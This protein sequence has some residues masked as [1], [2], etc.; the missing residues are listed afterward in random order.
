[1]SRNHILRK[2]TFRMTQKFTNQTDQE[3]SDGRE[4]NGKLAFEMEQANKN[5]P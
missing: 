4:G 2:D 1:M 3:M 5:L